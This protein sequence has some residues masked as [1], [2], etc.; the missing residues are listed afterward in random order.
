[1]HLK[2]NQALK[3][4]QELTLAYLQVGRDIQV[5]RLLFKTS[6]LVSAMLLKGGYINLA[7]LNSFIQEVNEF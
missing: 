4:L 2:D 3:V 7:Q 6:G 5:L 1:M